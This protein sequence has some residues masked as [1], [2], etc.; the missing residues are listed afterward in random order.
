MRED[1]KT[2]AVLP[3][4]CEYVVPAVLG[5]M[6]IGV[7]TLVD[8]IF[9]GRYV[10]PKGLAALA[11]IYPLIGVIFAFGI[12]IGVGS[13]TR[14]SIH[15]GAGRLEKSRHYLQNS[16]LLQLLAGAVIAALCLV[17]LDPI[18]RL[19]GASGELAVLARSYA[20]IAVCAA[21]FFIMSVTLDQLTRNDGRPNV[22]V[23]VMGSGA[24]INIV[25]DWLMISKLQWGVAGAAWATLIANACTALALSI[26]FIRGFSNLKLERLSFRPAIQAKIM[27]AGLAAFMM[28][29]SF[30][31]MMFLHNRLLLRYGTPDDVA[32]F[33][34]LS[35]ITSI[36][37]MLYI[38]VNDGVQPLI[39]YHYGAKLKKR[40]KSLI[41]TALG[42]TLGV[43][44]LGMLII[45]L[46]PHQLVGIFNAG[47]L[48]AARALRIFTVTLP[49]T[50]L[51]FVTSGI[52]QS[53][54][55]VKLAAIGILGRSFIF[56]LPGLFL[57]PLHFGTTGVWLATPLA[58]ITTLICLLIILP[59]TELLS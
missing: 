50:A 35:Y 24:I 28:E 39:S 21:P 18:L 5:L 16:F 25:L 26:Y 48:P 30:S 47:E 54:G 45:Q 33:G 58:D 11:L 29:L 43:G 3:L 32:I 20:A 57:L 6:I 49:L 7:Y 8:G 19:L 59:R 37:I 36:F 53:M 23:M 14:I 51:I 2:K 46:F 13:A 34:I 44:L 15:A 42:A 1:L 12:M 55:K 52:L 9:I 41:L 22:A 38:G 40:L 56:L 10:G 17:L 4:F 31:F 27:Q